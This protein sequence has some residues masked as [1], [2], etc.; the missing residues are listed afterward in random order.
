MRRRA[1]LRVASRSCTEFP[2][3][4]AIRPRRAVISLPA[5]LTQ[6][7][8]TAVMNIE[9]EATRRLGL[10]Y[11]IVLGPFGGGSSTEKLTATVSNLGGL[12]SYGAHTLSP[13]QIGEVVGKIKSLT[14]HPFNMNLWVSDHDPGGDAISQ[15]DF[16][17]AFEFY[18]PYFRE[19]GL[20]KPALPARFYQSYADQIDAMIEAAPPVISFIFGL[21]S[22]SVLSACRYRDIVTMATVTSIAEAKLAEETGV[23]V[24]VA[25]GL[26]AGGHR[27]SFLAPAED[28]LMGTLALTPLIAD[29]VKV[30]VVAAGGIVDGRG[31]RAVLALGAQAAQIGTAFLACEESAAT[32][33]HR[34][35]LFGERSQRTTLSRGYTGRLARSIRNRWSEEMKSHPREILPFPI[36]GWLTSQLRAAALKAGRDDFVSFASGQA[37]PNLRHRTAAQLMEALIA[38]LTD[39]K[40]SRAL[41]AV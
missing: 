32:P 2:A 1:V 28:S 11:P 35:V 21:P 4:I 20:D 23:D 3:I 37:A 19:L 27:P 33:H 39:A 13:D 30:P 26:E 6:Y 41:E 16:D 18:A 8:E 15:A 12:G 36:Q 38:D 17:R 9:T 14:S 22:A 34:D 24:I 7:R 40:A 29:R 31:I 5:W 25:T 10:R